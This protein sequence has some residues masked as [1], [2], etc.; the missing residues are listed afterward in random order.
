[1]LLSV[2]SR[3]SPGS[4]DTSVPSAAAAL[5]E[6][7]PERGISPEP[8]GKGH[9]YPERINSLFA[10]LLHELEGVEKRIIGWGFFGVRVRKLLNF[11]VTP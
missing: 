11:Y 9:V 3:V 5:W 2:P 10:D 4:R 1:M 7:H 8:V 6:L